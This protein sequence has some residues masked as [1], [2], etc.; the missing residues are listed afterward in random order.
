MIRLILSFE[1]ESY[2]PYGMNFEQIISYL[3]LYYF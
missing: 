2:G 3:Y 1:Y